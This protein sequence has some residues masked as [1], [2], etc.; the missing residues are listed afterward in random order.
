MRDEYLVEFVHR[1]LQAREVRQ[2][3]DPEIKHEQITIRIPH[4]DEDAARL[5]LA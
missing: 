2:R 1:Q 3:P 4:L 5:A